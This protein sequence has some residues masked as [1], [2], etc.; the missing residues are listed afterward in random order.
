MRS[1]LPSQFVPLGK[2]LQEWGIKGQ[3]RFR[4]FNS[5]SDLYTGLSAIYIEGEAE[6]RTL[7][8]ARRHG[9]D[10]LFKLKD[11]ENPETARELRGKILGLP[12]DQLPPLSEGEIYL[13]DLLGLK[14][15]DSD[16]LEIG[17]VVG[18]LPVGEGQVLRIE[19]EEGMEALVPFRGDF[20]L[21]T[22]LEKEKIRL[23]ELAK[24]LL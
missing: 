23:T 2:I 5:E 21:E 14:V 15:V 4:S 6:P 8:Q 18:F 13:N 10:W 22:N 20:V 17:K 11:Y 24:E 7:E 9:R 16:G 19:R 12:R 1:S 3:L